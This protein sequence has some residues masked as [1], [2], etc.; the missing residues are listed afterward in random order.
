MPYQINPRNKGEKAPSFTTLTKPIKKALK[1]ITPLTARG[2]RDLQMTFEDQLNSLIY[3]Y[4]EEHSSAQH[5]LQVLKED[6]FARDNMAPK[7]GIE[8]SSFSEA[9]NTRGLQQLLEIFEALVDEARTVLPKEYNDLGDLTLIDGS[10]IILS[11]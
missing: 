7:E 2:N 3:Y 1:K 4:L 9:I 8:K 6:D 11:Y 10:L 5:L